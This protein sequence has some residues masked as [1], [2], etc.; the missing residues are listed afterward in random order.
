MM[1]LSDT[2]TLLARLAAA[3]DRV[4]V[5]ARVGIGAPFPLF[6]SPVAA[7]D[8][9]VAVRAVAST[10]ADLGRPVGF[11]VRRDESALGV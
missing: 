6:D 7:A 2:A 1:N 8:A 3:E 4:M 11:T 9:A 5:S 10:A